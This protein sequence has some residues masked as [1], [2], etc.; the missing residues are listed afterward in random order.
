MEDD[1]ELREKIMLPALRHAGFDAVGL[2]NALQL[3]RMW[4]SSHFDLVLL[5]VGLPDDDGVEIARHL[6]ELSQSLGIVMYTGHGRSVDRIRALRAGVDAYLVK[7]LDMDELIETLRNV[8]AR[9]A[10]REMPDAPNGGGWALRRHGWS[11]STP[12]GATVALNHAERQIMGLLATRPNQPVSRETLI[13]HLTSDVEG[14]DPHRLEMLVYRLRRKCIDVS[15]E[16]LPLKAVRG[17]GYLFE[18]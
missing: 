7:P 3:Y 15:G 17:V 8:R 11:L 1:E 13:A 16:A 4:A 6:R 18:R 12:S 14:F 2:A 9:Q 5:D 10:G